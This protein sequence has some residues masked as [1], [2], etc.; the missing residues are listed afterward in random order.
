MD[1]NQAQTNLSQPFS[2]LIYQFLSL[3]AKQGRF[4]DNEFTYTSLL[5]IKT[6]P[7]LSHL[8]GV[9]IKMSLMRDEIFSKISHHA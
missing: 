6:Q 7:S 4:L 9:E 2:V 3:P 1:K 8:L 5:I